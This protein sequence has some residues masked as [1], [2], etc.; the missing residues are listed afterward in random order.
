M[1][2]EDTCLDGQR[3]GVIKNEAALIIWLEIIV[4]LTTEN[5]FIGSVLKLILTRIVSHKVKSLDGYKI[6]FFF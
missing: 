5:K 4:L 6:T 2:I 1:S 3:C